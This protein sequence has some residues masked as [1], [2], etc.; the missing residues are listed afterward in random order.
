[1]TSQSVE[2]EPYKE[3]GFPFKI[4]LPP[5]YLAGTYTYNV[6]VVSPLTG[7]RATGLFDVTVEA[8]RSF[9]ISLPVAMIEVLPEEERTIPVEIIGA[10]NVEMDI[11][12]DWRSSRMDDWNMTVINGSQRLMP[13]SNGSGA[14]RIRPPNGTVVRHGSRP[15]AQ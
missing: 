14:I 1:M 10:A 5:R 15:E 11:S 9:D 12:I 4:T 6:E 8:D 2:V 3:M 13:F 7:A